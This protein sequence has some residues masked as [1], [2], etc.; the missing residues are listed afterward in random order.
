MDEDKFMIDIPGNIKVRMELIDGIGMKE[1]GQTVIVGVISAIIGFIINFL[2]KNYIVALGFFLGVTA[3]TFVSLMKDSKT[4]TSVADTIFDYINFFRNQKF[5]K[6]NAKENGGTN[7][8][9]D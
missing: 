9:K 6:Y 5:F 8:V 3:L 7:Y 2:F 4:N 1:L